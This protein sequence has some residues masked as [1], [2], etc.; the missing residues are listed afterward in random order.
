MR[1]PRILRKKFNFSEGEQT[2]IPDTKSPIA[3]L[4]RDITQTVTGLAAA[5]VRIL[6]DVK[7]G[8]IVQVKAVKPSAESGSM[9]LFSSR[10]TP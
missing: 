1:A 10:L 8:R 9:A 2:H 5:V 7:G 4:A 6:H 3:V